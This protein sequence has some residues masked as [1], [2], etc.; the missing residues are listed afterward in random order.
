MKMKKNVIITISVIVAA[1][2]ALMLFSNLTSRKKVDNNFVEVKKGLFE[3][4]V[5]N[6]GELVAESSVDILGPQ[7]GQ[8]SNQ[9]GNQGGNHGGN[10]GGRGS[11]MHAVDFKIQDMVPEGTIVRKGD[12]IAQLDRTSYDNTLKDAIETLKTRQTNYEM[13]L[14][15]TT[16]VLTNL[17]DGIKNQRYQVEEAAINLDQSK[18]EP[19]AIIRQAETELNK[20]QRA[21]EQLI[22]SYELQKARTRTQT[23][24]Q[25]MFLERQERLVSDIQ[26]FLAQ[27]T[28]TAPSDGM[29]IYKKDRN[30]TKRKTGSS[31]NQFDRIIATL[32]DLSSM[33]SRVYVS[34]VD[35]IKILPD[36]KVTITV[37]AFPSKQ[38]TGK[39]I[40]IGNIGEQLPN[41]DSKMFEVMIR[42]DGSDQTLRPA[43][44][45]WNK[46]IIKT[47]EDVIYVPLEC[48]QADVDSTTFVYKKNKTKQIVLLGNEDDKN[49]IIKQGLEPGDQL[50]IIPPEDH[51]NFRVTGENLIPDEK[52]GK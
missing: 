2:A 47:F 40:S 37:D 42:I 38:Y 44:T 39:V 33:L 6:A 11:D 36:L 30:G 35:V 22:K 26:E 20:Q 13:K 52:Q 25:K 4:T 15:D 3:L 5:A 34:E 45:T 48:V 19:P 9:G 31:V 29:V 7:L 23:N 1:I 16:V 8:R 24:H 17:R 10:Q 21:L 32:P 46:I 43:M 49:V 14:L 18:Y 41:S 27:F 28:I 12:Y 50:Y 51:E